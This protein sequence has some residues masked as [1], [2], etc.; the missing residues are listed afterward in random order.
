MKRMQSGF[1]LIELVVVIVILGILAV[2]AIPRFIDLAADAEG[3]AANGVA[4][5][6]SSGSAINYAACKAGNTD[7]VTIDNCTDASG[8]LQ[9]SVMPND[10]S[11][12]PYTIT[13][14]AVAD[15]AAVTCTVNDSTSTYSATFT[16]LGT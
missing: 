5:A 4:A 16:A 15:D 6:L 10:S 3:A 14:L 8:V 11:G 2:T 13:A 7:C 1:T 9:G 12:N